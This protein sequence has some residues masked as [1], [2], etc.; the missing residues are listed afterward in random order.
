MQREQAV[1]IA[2]QLYNYYTK[3]G[4]LDIQTMM[5]NNYKMMG[6]QYQIQQEDIEEYKQVIGSGQKKDFEQL[7]IRYF[8][9]TIQIVNLQKKQKYSKIANDRLE[10]ARKIFRK[11]DADNSG[12]ITSDEVRGLLIETY[13]QVGINNYQPTDEDLKEWMNMT[14]TNGDGLISIEEFE[15]LVIRSLQSSGIEI[16]QK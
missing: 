6:K 12:S 4:S 8:C 5:S 10:I 3:K 15:D 11:F 14:D 9:N 1:Q 2:G 13:K 7:C 16:Y